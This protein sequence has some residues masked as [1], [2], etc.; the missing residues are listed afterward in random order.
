MV[1]KLLMTK[2][3]YAPKPSS[4]HGKCINTEELD[5]F[6]AEEHTVIKSNMDD[7][8]GYFYA[9]FYDRNYFWG[10]VLNVFSPD[11]DS[12]ATDVEIRFLRYRGG[13]SR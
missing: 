2:D 4:S 8:K 5:K 13:L 12:D 10:K 9:A 1:M 6:L 11:S 3:Q 7:K